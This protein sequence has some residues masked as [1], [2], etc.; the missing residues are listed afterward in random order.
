MA[1]VAAA[2]QHHSPDHALGISESPFVEREAGYH[3]IVVSVNVTWSVRSAAR[4]CRRR[5]TTRA[6]R[7]CRSLLEPPV[8]PVGYAE[9][10]VS[11]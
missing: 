3:L 1:T 5:P 8:D 6:R 10:V 2:M 11:V 9:S 7:Y 4:Q